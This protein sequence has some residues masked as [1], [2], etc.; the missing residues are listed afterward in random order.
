VIDWDKLAR[1]HAKT[2]EEM[3]VKRDL[4]DTILDM[5]KNYPQGLTSSKISHLLDMQGFK[6]NDKK[7]KL[8]TLYNNLESLVKSGR[9]VN[10]PLPKTG[11]R[12]RSPYSYKLVLEPVHS[13][14]AT[15]LIR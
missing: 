9:V 1:L 12:G 5:L 2:I 3:R 4:K 6:V 10:L 15:G 14:N 7:V 8:D 13:I 11:K